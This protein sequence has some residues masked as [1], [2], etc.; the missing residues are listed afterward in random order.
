MN[1]AIVKPPA[2]K[3]GD[4]V[5]VVAPSSPSEQGRLLAGIRHLQAKRFRV[6]YLPDLLHRR[7]RFLAG[8]DEERAEELRL[9]FEDPEVRA[10]FVARGG[11][12]AQRLLD[13]LD[14]QVIRRNAKIFLGY[15]D[16]TALLF[17]MVERCGLVCFHGPLVTEMSTLSPWTERVLFRALTSPEPARE[18]P[19]ARSG[20]IRKGIARGKLV[21]GNLSTLC[22]TLGT[23]H[24]PDTSGKILFLEDRGEKPY[25]ID[26]MLVQLKQSGKLAG[27]AAVLL[28]DLIPGATAEEADRDDTILRE[29]LFDNL[30]DLG[31]PVASGLPA[32]HGRRNLTLP[33]GVSV[34]VDA[35]RN[36]LV[37]LESGVNPRA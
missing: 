32:G 14:P 34:E 27:A 25:R 8:D 24:E 7:R 18:V 3:R 19:L 35:G 20:W 1:N 22:A 21:G 28:G 33:L 15:S 31:V 11:Y 2:L 17:F 12:G 26:R 37:F 6:R 16:V 23:P 5:A 10:I 30:R 36:R 13:R 29:V 4:L 9:M